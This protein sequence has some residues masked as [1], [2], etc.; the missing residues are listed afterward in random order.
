MSHIGD[1]A[2]RCGHDES[3]FCPP[4]GC[5]QNARNAAGEWVPYGCARAHGWKT[6]NPSPN[7]CIGILPVK[8]QD[9]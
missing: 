3:K 8:E 1:Y 4:E 6:G 2:W 5:P 7:E 9:Q